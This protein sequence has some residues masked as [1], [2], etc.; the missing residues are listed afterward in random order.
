MQYVLQVWKSLSETALLLLSDLF[1][2]TLEEYFENKSNHYI[3]TRSA[4]RLQYTDIMNVL[5]F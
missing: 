3:H 5:L 2:A 1:Q 4:K